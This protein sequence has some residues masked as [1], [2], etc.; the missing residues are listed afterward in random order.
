MLVRVL[1]THFQRWAELNWGQERGS[2]VISQFISIQWAFLIKWE[3]KSFKGSFP[4]LE[5]S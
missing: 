3:E 4:I 5:T 2:D 1:Q